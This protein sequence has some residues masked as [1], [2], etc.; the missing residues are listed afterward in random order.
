MG[1]KTYTES[2]LRRIFKNSA[3]KCHLDHKP[4]KFELYGNLYEAGGWEVDHSVAVARGGTKA[5]QNLYPACPR[6]NRQ[7]Q[8]ESSRDVRARNG[9]SRAPLNEKRR[10]QELEKQRKGGAIAGGVAG[11]LIGGPAGLLWGA[12][13]GFGVGDSLDPDRKA[14]KR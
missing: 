4:L 7:K 1:R 12:L 9:F 2:E 13:A 3:G 6:C 14:K 11:A 10:E 5:I 8:A